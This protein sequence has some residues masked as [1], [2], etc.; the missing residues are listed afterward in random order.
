MRRGGLNSDHL[1]ALMK[2][3]TDWRSK[4]TSKDA[5]LV[6]ILLRENVALYAEENQNVKILKNSNDW[7]FYKSF[8]LRYLI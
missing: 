3:S 6:D 8:L 5:M 1:E 4:L 2:S 7:I